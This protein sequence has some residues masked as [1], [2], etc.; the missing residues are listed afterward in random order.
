MVRD[1]HGKKMSKSFGNAVDPLDWMDAYGS[2]PLRFTL[3]RGANPGTDVPIGEEWVQGSRNFCNKLWNAARFALLNGA[4]TA[5]P[6]PAAAE[7]S[8]VDRWL[9]SRLAT[10]VE[11]VDADYEDFE[12]AKAA[13]AL[14]HF[15]WDDFCDWY[16]E[17]AK[18]PLAAGGESAVRTQQVLGHVL[19]TV[20][21]LL[22]P[23]V[24]FV[25]ETLWTTLTGGESVVVAPWP[26]A[27][28]DR[29][30]PAAEAG[31]AALQDLVT[32]VRRFRSEQGLRPAQ[33]VAAR[34]TG[35]DV[36]GLADQEPLVRSLTRLE[37]PADGFAPTASVSVRGARVELDLSGAIDIAAER[38]R[39][40]KDLAAADKELQTATAKLDSSDFV[41]KA[42]EPVV[43]KVRGRLAAARADIERISAQLDALPER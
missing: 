8:T 18:V 17:L 16:V 2:D 41:T 36:A 7:L 20:L 34:L 6:P 21:R 4:T 24:P 3:A 12:F 10:V 28:P 22:H 13:E 27:D 30:D 31:F 40:S 29:R 42:P 11:E 37:E 14:Y 26:A 32:E 19:D 15:I 25:T 5:T 43:A 35:L 23:I 38:S 1:K 33:R 9:L 39:L